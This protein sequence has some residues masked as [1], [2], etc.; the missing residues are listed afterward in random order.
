MV[1]GYAGSFAISVG[2]SLANSPIVAWMMSSSL[3]AIQFTLPPAN[4]EQG[5]NTNSTMDLSS[6]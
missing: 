3:L 4:G 5:A 2:K 6:S 1:S